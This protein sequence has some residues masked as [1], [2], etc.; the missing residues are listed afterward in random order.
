MNRLFWVKYFNSRKK[1]EQWEYE[2]DPHHEFAF[3]L[4][5]L[6]LQKNQI[7]STDWLSVSPSWALCLIVA[8][9]KLF[10][11][12]SEECVP[13]VEDAGFKDGSLRLE[14]KVLWNMGTILLTLADTKNDRVRKLLCVYEWG[15]RVIE[16]SAPLVETE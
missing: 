1:K 5:S 13:L 15:W 7:V 12:D 16:V 3:N 4:L 2:H 14:G 8:G 10:Y 6:G 9:T 11:L